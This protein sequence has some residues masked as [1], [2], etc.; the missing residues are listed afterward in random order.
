MS[1]VVIEDETSAFG[2]RWLQLIVGIVGMVAIANLQYGWTLFVNPIDSKYHFGRAAIQVAFSLFVL[3]ET[4]L[5]PFE[6]YLV[7]RFGP[8]LIVAFGGILV[9]A[10]WAIDSAADTP[11]LS[12][13]RGRNRCR[14]RLWNRKRQ[15]SQMVPDRRGL[16]AGLTAAGFGAGSALTIIP[17]AN[18]IKSS[19]YELAF[20]IFGIA[21][22]VVVFICALF[23]RAPQKG[24][25]P[26][27]VEKAR[28]STRDFAPTETL[29]IPVFWLL[30]VMF[31]LVAI[32]SLIAGT[33]GNWLPIFMLAMVFDWAA[34]LLALFV[35]KPLRTKW[36]SSQAEI[37]AA[38]W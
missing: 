13:R 32:G 35:L 1:S 10:A 12:W 4:W 28:Q 5:V 27:G 21:Q 6:A 29:K 8:R 33:K 3:A 16:A 36:V 31:T 23:L 19:G 14:D 20:S 26:V 11:I 15:R 2:N 34:A 24:E 25:V 37:R 17:I 30:Y 7:D 18:M 22:G 9:G 38:A